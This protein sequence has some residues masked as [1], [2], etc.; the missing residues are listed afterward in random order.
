MHYQ[1]GEVAKHGDLV[2][3]RDGYLEAAGIITHFT[4]NSDGGTC[5]AQFFAVARRQA[6]TEAW[7]PVLCVSDWCV[8][9]KECNKISV[10]DLFAAKEPSP[11]ATSPNAPA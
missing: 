3:K 9:L 2:I 5:N 7:F 4:P 11:Y 8:T 1:N 6:G 10:R